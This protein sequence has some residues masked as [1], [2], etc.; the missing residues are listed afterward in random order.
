MHNEGKQ[1]HVSEEEASGGSK[2][3]VVRWVLILGTLLAIGLLS[4]VWIT[5]AVSNTDPIADEASVSRQIDEQQED[6]NEGTD[7]IILPNDTVGSDEPVE[8]DGLNVIPNEQ[9]G[10]ATEPAQ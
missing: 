3:G 4:I 8:Q 7:S 10:A 5:G 2:E 9:D 1:V 6:R